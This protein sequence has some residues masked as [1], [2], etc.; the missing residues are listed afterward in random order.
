MHN[1]S[2]TPHVLSTFNVIFHVMNVDV[3]NTLMKLELGFEG[4]TK[5]QFQYGIG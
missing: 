4:A 2:H 3:A 5:V 1:Y